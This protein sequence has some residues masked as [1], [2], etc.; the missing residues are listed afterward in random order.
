MKER[1]LTRVDKKRRRVSRKVSTS[2]PAS[3]SHSPTATSFPVLIAGVRSITRW[4]PFKTS[5]SFST[6][7]SR[8]TGREDFEVLYPF[9]GLEDGVSSN[10]DAPCTFGWLTTVFCLPCLPLRLPR[11]SITMQRVRKNQL[12]GGIWPLCTLVYEIQR[13]PC[14][15]EYFVDF[16]Q[17]PLCVVVFGVGGDHYSSHQ[18]AHVAYASTDPEPCS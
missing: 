1:L 9:V 10:N 11:A 16:C 5:F 8:A 6:S 13:F 12:G 15:T 7:S 4:Y 2:F 18:K 14:L 3:K 17:T